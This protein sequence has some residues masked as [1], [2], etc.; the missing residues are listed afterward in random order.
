MSIFKSLRTKLIV[1]TTA[2]VFFT[3]ILNLTI[4]IAAS[5]KSLTHNVESDL[6]SIGQIAKVAIGSSL[7]KIKLGVEFIAASDL[8]SDAEAAKPAMLDMLN[9]QFKDLLNL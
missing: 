8:I 7:D 3:A 4:G 9:K 6:A 5:Y 2:I 1:I